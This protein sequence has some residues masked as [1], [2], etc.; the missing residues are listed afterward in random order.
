[1]SRFSLPGFVHQ[2]LTFQYEAGCL[3]FAWHLLAVSPT[4]D[5]CPWSPWSPCS[6]SCGAGS[7]SRRRACVCEA[8]GDA[9]CPAE[10]E[11]ERNS[12][13]TQLCYK[14]PCPGTQG[15]TGGKHTA[16]QMILLVAECV[17]KQ[18]EQPVEFKTTQR[19]R[20]HLLFKTGSADDNSGQSN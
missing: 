18:Q 2:R 17:I 8:A 10:I 12:E 15:K 5:L 1:M 16:Q 9:A 11:A 6:R 19:C 7:V 20:R 4:D 14:Q 3:N 13:E